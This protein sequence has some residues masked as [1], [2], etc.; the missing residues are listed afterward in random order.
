MWVRS[1]E[2]DNLIPL[3]LSS[4]DQSCPLAGSPG[5]HFGICKMGLTIVSPSRD[6]CGESMSFY[7]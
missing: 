5:P 3:K 7:L 2:Q 4:L 1:G 6:G